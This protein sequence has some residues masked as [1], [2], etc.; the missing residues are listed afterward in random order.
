M[1]IACLTTV[2]C[3]ITIEA[4]GAAVGSSVSSVGR[5]VVATRG[6]F[7]G[8]ELRFSS[9]GS[10][11]P[12]FARLLA[13]SAGAAIG[14][15]AFKVGRVFLLLFEEIGDVEEGVPFESDV[16]KRG[17]HAGKNPGDTALIDGAG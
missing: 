6:R 11:R 3:F 15:G 10:R 2:G 9:L 13:A 8:G 17:L 1:V 4:L 12:L 7:G 14:C 5:S 16:D